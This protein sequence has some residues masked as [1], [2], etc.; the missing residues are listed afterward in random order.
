VE[1]GK[2]K[3]ENGKW[4]MENGKPKDGL[5]ALAGDVPRL[6][7]EASSPVFHFP[8]SIFHSPFSINP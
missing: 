5:E 7:A 8:F 4:K 6:P 2:W 1:N 3:M